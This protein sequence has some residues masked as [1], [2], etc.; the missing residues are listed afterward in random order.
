MGEP[1]VEDTIAI[2]RGLKGRYEVHH[3]VRIKDS[4]LIAAAT[5]P[6]YSALMHG[7]DGQFAVVGIIALALIMRLGL[8]RTSVTAFLAPTATPKWLR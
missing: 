8:R 5:A 7:T 6:L 2:L 3:G 1:S 4:A